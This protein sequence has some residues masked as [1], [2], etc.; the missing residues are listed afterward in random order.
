MNLI[1]CT[2]VIPGR[3]SEAEASRESSSQQPGLLDSGLR[4][5]SSPRND[6]AYDSNFTVTTLLEVKL[7]RRPFIR[8][9]T[10]ADRFDRT[11]SGRRALK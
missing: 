8:H 5:L 2:V 11:A 10:A 1:I 4:P 9:H 7:E 3:R 6:A